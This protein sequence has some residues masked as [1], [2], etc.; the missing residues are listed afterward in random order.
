[1]IGYIFWTAAV[2]LGFVLAIAYLCYRM[3][4]YALRKEQ[5][6]TDEIQ[7]PEGEIYEAFRPSMEKWAREVREMK[8]E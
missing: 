6:Q 8:S 4:F 7:I 1:M 2:L 3:A 5:I